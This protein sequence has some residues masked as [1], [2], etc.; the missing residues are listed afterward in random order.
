MRFLLKEIQATLDFSRPNNENGD[1]IYEPRMPEKDPDNFHFPQRAKLKNIT[2][3]TTAS[4]LA[5][6]GC[7]NHCSFCLVPPF[8]NSGPLW[9]GRSPEN[10]ICEMKELQYELRERLI[11]AGKLIDRKARY[12]GKS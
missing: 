2:S 12:L 5:S 4:I 11:P 1:F 7:Y 10:I 6:R 8:Y 3:V 9:R